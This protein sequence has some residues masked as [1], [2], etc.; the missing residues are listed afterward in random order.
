[1]IALT[2]EKYN[3]DLLK[4]RS[5][6]IIEALELQMNALMVKLQAH[7]V[8]DKLSGQVLHHRTGT[9]IASII[10][11][12]VVLSASAM[13]GMVTG[14]SGP[15]WYGRVHEYGGSFV[16]SRKLKRPA[17]MVRRK[18]GER[19]MTGSPYG[20]HFPE[21]SFMRSSLDDMRAEITE[22]LGMTLKRIVERA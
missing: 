2:F 6:E 12:P 20:I 22:K 4:Q 1:M 7:I 18:G 14:A 5:V 8:S 3:P 16:T 19:V 9:L 21:R 11:H 17:H 13:V 15:A 10:T